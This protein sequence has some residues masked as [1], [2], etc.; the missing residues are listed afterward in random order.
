MKAVRFNAPGDPDRVLYADDVDVPE[1]GRGEVLVRMLAA[2]VNPSDLMYVRG[3]YTVPARCPTTPGFEG[4]GIV[5]ASGGGLRGWLFRG[6]RVVVL[7]RAGGN[8]AEKAIVPA[9]QVIPVSSRL[10]MEQCATFF[11]NPATAWVMTQD[12][13]R[14]PKGAWLVQSAAGSELGRMII[15]LGKTQEFR[16]LNLVRR[17]EVAEDLKRMGADQTI[18]FRDGDD[19]ST[20]QKQIQSVIGPDGVR[21]AVDAVGGHTGSAMV[22][23]LGPGGR[24]LAYGTLSGQP[25][26]FSPRSLMTVGSRLEG[27]WLGRFMEQ[28]SLP[29]KLKLVKR[30]TRL[31]QSGVLSSEISG[32]FALSQIHDAVRA[33]EDSRAR[34]KT[35]L[36]MAD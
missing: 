3:H 6:K 18:V 12:V 1:P 32:S 25:L 29:Y 5:E 23:S 21:F 14:I 4:V 17:S 22:R 35:L 8:W 16:T 27:F 36:R 11:V 28:A 7:N 33:A 10:S 31:I 34:G 30:L 24:M 9:N 15:R 20:L 13:L 2:P 19:E 26:S